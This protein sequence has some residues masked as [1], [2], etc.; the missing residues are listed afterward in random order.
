MNKSVLAVLCLSLMG[1]VG[2]DSADQSTPDG[3]MKVAYA[4]IQAENLKSFRGALEGDALK[5][6]G[7]QNSLIELK[8]HVGSSTPTLK[9]EAG[10]TTETRDPINSDVTRPSQT[11]HTATVTVDGKEVL[12]ADVRCLIEY[13]YKNGYENG[14]YKGKAD[15]RIQDLTRL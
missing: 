5:F 4:A 9:I 12:K 3:V 11:T 2:C 14:R 1:V 13:S 6:Y 7:N 8:R 10:V 15:C